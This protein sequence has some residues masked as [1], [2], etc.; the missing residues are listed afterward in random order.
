MRLK[1]SQLQLFLRGSLSTEAAAAA[2]LLLLTKACHYLCQL[3]LL[4]ML[5][6]M[7][8][9]ALFTAHDSRPIRFEQRRLQCESVKHIHGSIVQRIVEFES[10]ANM[11][12]LISCWISALNAWKVRYRRFGCEKDMHTKR[13]R[14]FTEHPL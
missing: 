3:C 4:L 1:L 7:L 12:R 10:V 8:M 9:L 2:L 14:H 6:H 5:M 13:H 11:M